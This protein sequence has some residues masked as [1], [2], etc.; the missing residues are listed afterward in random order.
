MNHIGYLSEIVEGADAPGTTL[1]DSHDLMEA[2]TRGSASRA[3]GMGRVLR[4]VVSIKLHAI[5]TVQSVITHADCKMAASSS[6][7]K[8]PSA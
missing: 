3:E 8:V 2:H 1:R 7:L 5:L 6:S 4:T